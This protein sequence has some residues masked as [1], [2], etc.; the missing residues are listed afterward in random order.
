MVFATVLV[1]EWVLVILAEMLCLVLGLSL[2]MLI[3]GG[4]VNKGMETGTN[5]T[6]SKKGL[7]VGFLT[8]RQSCQL[9]RSETFE[10]LINKLFNRL[11]F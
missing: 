4:S 5:M 9:V 10:R 8:L 7:V 6:K 1:V 3:I 11:M 2:L